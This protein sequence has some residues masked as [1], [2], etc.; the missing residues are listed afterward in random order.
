MKP[1]RI[2][3]MTNMSGLHPL[4][5]DFSHTRKETNSNLHINLSNVRKVD[6]IGLA[7]SLGL[8]FLGKKPPEEYRVKLFWSNS[9]NVNYQ[10]RK[11]GIVEL[12]ETLSL[13]NEQN[14]STVDLFDNLTETPTIVSLA[15]DDNDVFYSDVLQEVILFY[16]KLYTNRQDALNSFSRSLKKFM[17]RDIPRTF[18]HEQIIKVFL[19]L[20]KNTLDHSFG[21]G[22]AGL[23][24]H[25]GANNEKTIQFIYCDRYGR[26]NMP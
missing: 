18:N 8:F 21:F 3:I 20:A 25:D 1:H 10:L 7:I 6:S 23:L 24:I 16:P 19:E 5:N 11:L 15:S 12:L 26:R 9:D 17:A 13:K 4:L 22:V 2:D 14:G